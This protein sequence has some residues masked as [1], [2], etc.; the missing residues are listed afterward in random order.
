MKVLQ[1]IMP[2]ILFADNVE[3]H[4]NYL[5]PL[6]QL[7]FRAL[8]KYHLVVDQKTLQ[9]WKYPLALVAAENQQAL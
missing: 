7:D 3:L 8:S 4:L 1:I 9:I 5:F 2:K 6:K